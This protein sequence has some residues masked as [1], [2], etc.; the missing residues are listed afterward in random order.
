M[1]KYRKRFE[2]SLGSMALKIFI[3]ISLKIFKRNTI[4]FD[5]K[6]RSRGSVLIYYKTDPFSTQW[7]A[8][9]FKHTNNREIEILVEVCRDLGFDVLLVDRVAK[10]DEISIYKKRQFR[11]FIS[12]CGGNS[13]PLHERIR[14]EFSGIATCI[15]YCAGVEPELS[16]L[17]TIKRHL[18]FEERHGISIIHRRLVAGT[19]DNWKRRFRN[20][21]EIWYFGNDF[22][23]EA[24]E[25]KY[26]QPKKAILPTAF[27]PPDSCQL[28]D[29]GIKNKYSAMFIGGDGLICKGLDLV[30]DLFLSLPKP[31]ELH[32]FCP[33]GEN[34]F[35]NFY[36]PL[37]MEV[38]NINVHGFANVTSNRFRNIASKCL[39]N[40][41]PSGAEACAT[42]VVTAMKFGVLPV[43]TVQCGVDV[44]EF[45]YLLGANICDDLKS[46]LKDVEL[47]SAENL[48]RRLISMRSECE[49]YS[50]LMYR[51]R[52]HEYVKSSSSEL[53]DI[54]EGC[55]G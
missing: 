18:D 55:S 34:D 21:S 28:F 12:N 17:L 25:E 54:A 15:C 16:N 13:A 43:V 11:L 39:L 30:L 8:K 29:L 42:S 10:W 35:W 37:L 14:T 41:F 24:W 22:N 5:A 7:L 1:N 4:W 3:K 49:K 26:I 23:K 46:T 9:T 47:S 20:C 33:T 6:N 44:K 19:P 53:T 50:D 45:G 31:W 2:F 27:S 36:G 40:L 38:D 51:Q 48:Q 52:I 32:V